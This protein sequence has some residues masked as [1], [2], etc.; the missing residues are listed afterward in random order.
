MTQVANVEFH[1]RLGECIRLIGSDGATALVSLFGGQ[2]VSWKDENGQ[3]ML[4]LSS[5]AQ[6]GAAIRGGIPVCFPQF[7]GLGNL[8]KHGFARSTRWRHRHGTQFALDIAPDTWSGFPFPCALTIDVQ[9]GPQTL[10]ISFSVDNVGTRELSFTGALHTYLAVPTL[11][12]VS[13]DRL[14]ESAITFGSE[15]DLQIPGVGSPA[16]LSFDGDPHML[17]AQ[18]GFPDAVVWNIGPHKATSLADLGIGENNHY[19]CIEAAV[20]EPLVVAPGSRWVGSQ[21]MVRL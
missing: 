10:V 1:E 13:V 15:V 17:C 21:V 18:T 14:T 7:A 5:L 3:E 8:P 19:V 6:A 4:F 9:L 16:L 20:L 11:E 12:G 2:V